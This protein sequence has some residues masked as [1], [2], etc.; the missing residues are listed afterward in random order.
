MD[1]YRNLRSKALDAIPSLRT[2]VIFTLFLAS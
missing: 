1:G 2:V